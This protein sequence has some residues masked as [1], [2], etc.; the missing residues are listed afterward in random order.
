MIQNKT[1]QILRNNI[2]NIDKNIVQLLSKRQFL[3]INIIE[4]KINKNLVVRDQ[5][6][7]KELFKYLEKIGKK[8]HLNFSYIKN[9]YNIIIQQ[10]ILIQNK[11]YEK[12][13]NEK[14]KL[15][16]KICAYLGPMGSYS[17]FVFNI[18]NKNPNKSLIRKK[19]C[20]TFLDIYKFL[21]K[22]NNYIGLLP[23]ENNSSGKINET[24]EI[25]FKEK[26]FIIKEL[27][28]KIQHSLLV[29]PETQFNDI[30]YIY[31]HEQPF[32]QCSIFLKNFPHWK[33]K[34][35]FSTSEAMNN[36][37]V[38]NNKIAAVI[39]NEIGGKLYNLT[40]IAKNLSN[41]KN[42]ITR[43]I[44]ISKKEKKISKT[45]PC[46]TT[47]LISLNKEEKNLQKIL[48]NLRKNNLIIQKITSHIKKNKKFF[49]IDILCH[50]QKI[51]M[52][53]FL[54]KIKKFIFFIKILGCYPICNEQFKI[55]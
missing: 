17:S 9:I 6:R 46:K 16:K 13:I 53:K 51:E 18:L 54:L 10:S 25:L 37:F 23:L 49:F 7:E 40:T 41:Q 1:L 42:N 26:I 22:S 48:I 38:K 14:Q 39:G 12:E 45:I 47:I 19:I 8:Y 31:S 20:K 50:I 36:I 2:N 30:K 4:E 15:K 24:Y 34:N 29:L 55:K 3:S 33:K 5:I 32:K 11:I 27:Y 52:Q 44:I 21:K 35:N 43:F 28:I